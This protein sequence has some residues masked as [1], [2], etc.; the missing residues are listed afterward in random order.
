MQINIYNNFDNPREKINL[1]VITL[2][3]VY[4]EKCPY[5]MTHK[6][7]L[8]FA[9]LCLKQIDDPNRFL[10]NVK[11]YPESDISYFFYL[12]G[13]VAGK[14]AFD[15]SDYVDNLEFNMYR[16]YLHYINN[17]IDFYYYYLNKRED[18]EKFELE[19]ASNENF[20]DRDLLEKSLTKAINSEIKNINTDQSPKSEVRSTHS[21]TA[22][23]F[24]FNYFTCNT[25][26]KITLRNKLFDELMD[27]EEEYNNINVRRQ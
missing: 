12:I 25:K 20:E 16:S 15:I 9:E 4:F 17:D 13:T 6:L 8:P 23:K 2:V 27:I 22:I 3:E 21:K 26:Q 1:V 24:N 11:V 18:Q 5:I 14:S 7:V 19:Y 10:N